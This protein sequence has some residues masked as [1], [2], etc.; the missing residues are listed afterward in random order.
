MGLRVEQALID[1]LDAVRDRNPRAAAAVDR[2]DLVIDREEVEIEQECIRLLA[3]Y[4][5]AAVDLRAICTFIKVNSDLERIADLAAGI[6]RRVEGLVADN[7][8][9]E[10]YEGYRQLADGAVD[11]L[12][13]TLRVLGAKDV[14]AASSVIAYDKVIDEH[15]ARCVTSALEAEGRR[16]GGAEPAMLII[17]VARALERVGDLCTNIAEDIIFLSTGDIVRHPK[18]F[19]DEKKPASR[20]K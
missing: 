11:I 17:N 1:A 14:D 2:N 20:P 6:A 8:D 5:P 16:L 12:R 10:H 4:Q 19:S 9:P 15:Y 18:A 7:A 13:K 3:L